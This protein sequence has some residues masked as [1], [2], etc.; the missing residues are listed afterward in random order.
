MKSF[1]EKRAIRPEEEVDANK[2]GLDAVRPLIEGN[3]TIQDIAE[4]LGIS[5]ENAYALVT[6]RLRS[7]RDRT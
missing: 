6:A 2:T 7:G 1:A 3:L 4:R 5:V